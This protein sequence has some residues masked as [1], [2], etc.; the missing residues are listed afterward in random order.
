MTKELKEL[1]LKGLMEEA[2]C[3]TFMEDE[4][5]RAAV[6]KLRLNIEES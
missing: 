2:V 6:E 5:F 1:A 3:Q 4:E